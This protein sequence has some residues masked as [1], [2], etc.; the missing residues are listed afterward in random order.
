MTRTMTVRIG[1]DGLP[2]RESGPWAH[3]KLYYAGRYFT[4]FNGGMKKKWPRRGYIDLL[5]GPGR[6]AIEG[7]DEEF[8][9]S[10]LIALATEPPFERAVFVESDPDLADALQQRTVAAEGRRVIIPADCNAPAT[11]ARIRQEIDSG[12]LAVCFVDLLGFACSIGVGLVCKVGQARRWRS[13]RAI[14]VPW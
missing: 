1:R 13:G 14:S 2:V 3:G 7:T 11:V 8:D 6:C 4:I 12:M 5:A 9:G 10:P